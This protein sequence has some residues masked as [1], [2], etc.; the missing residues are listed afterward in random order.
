MPGGAGQEAGRIDKLRPRLKMPTPMFA[1]PSPDSARHS[2]AFS[3]LVLWLVILLLALLA[4]AA[5][6][7]FSDKFPRPAERLALEEMIVIQIAFS[8]LLFPL[9]MPTISA[10]VLVIVATWPF[11]QLAGV[12]SS[13]DA[14]N[15]ITVAV[16]LSV[17]LAILGLWRMILRSQAAL[18]VGVAGVSALSLGG[19][20]L[21][22]LANEFGAGAAGWTEISPISGALATA[23]G[24]GGS[25]QVWAPMLALAAVSITVGLIVWLSRRRLKK[26]SKA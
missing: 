16:Y 1:A 25:P 4:P 6:V 24:K 12:L 10:T 11:L 19:I 20:L 8:S 21:W 9:L 13:A 5:G 23:H 26:Q 18:L 3:P 7:Q 15:V 17:W 2:S 14:V 22:Y